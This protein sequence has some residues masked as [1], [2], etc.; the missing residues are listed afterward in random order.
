M[1]AITCCLKT[2]HSVVLELGSLRLLLGQSSPSRS[3][4]GCFW[5]RVLHLV[6]SLAASGSEFSILFCL[7]LLPGQ[8]SPSCSVFGCF[9]VKFFLLDVSPPEMVGCLCLCSAF[10][11]GLVRLSLVQP[12]YLFKTSSNHNLT[13]H[14]EPYKGKTLARG[15]LH[16]PH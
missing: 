12:P 5:V 10:E 14:K 7:W 13:T 16:N 2:L 8:S 11:V 6:P 15:L 3:V 9:R 4:F 1:S